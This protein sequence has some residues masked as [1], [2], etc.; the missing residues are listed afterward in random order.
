MKSQ[1]PVC[2]H[3]AA[4]HKQR[5]IKLGPA[6]VTV[7]VAVWATP[8]A[9]AIQE[10]SRALEIE[11]LLTFTQVSEPAMSPSGEQVA[12]VATQMD[13]ETNTSVSNLWVVQ[14]DTGR[15]RQLTRETGRAHAPR[16]SHDESFLA[17]LS[18]RNEVTQ[19]Y[20]IRADG[21]EPWAMT[22]VEQGVDA[23][24]LSPN[25][26][27]LA[28]TAKPDKSDAQEKFERERGRPRVWGSA[29][30]DEWA[31]LWVADLVPEGL[32]VADTR[33]LSAAGQYVGSFVFAPTGDAVAYSAR[34]SPE[35]RSNRLSKIFIRGVAS[36]GSSRALAD[37]PGAET[38]VA[39]HPTHGLIVAATGH[40]LGTFNRKL[41]R[42]GSDGQSLEAFTEGLDEHARFVAMT[43]TSVFVEASRG[44]HR[45]IAR[46]GLLDD[47][48]HAR[49][50]FLSEQHVYQFGFDA[51][52]DG[53]R[54]AFLSES[55][56]ETANVHVADTD[57]F[58]PSRR[59]SFNPMEALR[60]GEQQVFSWKSG[61]DGETIEGILTLPVDYQ[62]STQAPLLLVIHG[63]PSG[64]SS[65]RFS[66]RR[67]AYPIQ[68]FAGRGYAI[69]QPNYRGS[70][71][72][73]ERFR[74]LNRGD[75][76]GKDWVDID[77]GVD[78]LI[79]RGIAD[80]SRLGIMGWSFGGHHT[81]WGITQTDRYRAASAGAG[82]NDLISMY[83]QT[84]LPEFYQTYLGP[85]PWE[86]F[87]L[88][89][90]RSAYRFVERVTTPLLIQVG[91]KD[92][93]VPAEQSIQFYEAVKAIGK[94]QTELIIYPGQ[95]H[96][97]REPR[98][99]RDLLIRNLDWFEKFIPTKTSETTS[100][101]RPESR[102]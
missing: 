62:E 6:L 65:D 32:R 49:T 102:E 59:T 29:Y 68:V 88:Y 16:W 63:G 64:V 7:C 2:G 54:V 38:P 75:I 79:E 14:T 55:A 43:D 41:W 60:L 57:N 19:I 94:T 67:G 97:V 53:S 83:S 80:P 18:D 42:V 66:G 82:A 23:F 47:D 51:N 89:E 17:F 46:I 44:V 58:T 22:D 84:D 90:E 21:G 20:G 50:Q 12:F 99:V 91:E 69:L 78:A 85:K 8:T 100:A 52:R 72:Y 24:R 95:P 36:D 9:T 45:G 15:P 25:G 28:W 35:L 37:L 87:G 71:G 86:D 77:S 93:R 4:N 26:Q 96:G 40:E 92:E 74:G 13:F 3:P 1:N 30:D 48:A 70:T 5:R 10:P 81:F 31:Q 34:P 33:R 61:A 73:G 76:S 11:D 27:H 56:G 98:L 101:L 39:W